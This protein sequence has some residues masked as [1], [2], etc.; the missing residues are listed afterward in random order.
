MEI[1]RALHFAP[2][3]RLPVGRQRSQVTAPGSARGS[4][5]GH[6]RSPGQDTWT[7]LCKAL[8]HPGRTQQASGKRG[9]GQASAAR[10]HFPVLPGA[11]RAG[12]RWETARHCGAAGE[13]CGREVISSPLC[14]IR[15]KSAA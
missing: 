14:A 8:R 6:S 9:A 15:R 7:L 4:P 12:G 10:S 1:H 3:P 2:G 13:P 5:R 11:C